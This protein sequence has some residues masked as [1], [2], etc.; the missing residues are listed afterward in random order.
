MKLKSLPPGIS[1]ANLAR[2]IAIL[3]AEG[4]DDQA[5]Y[6]ASHLPPVHDP[7]IGAAVPPDGAPEF[8]HPNET[9][10]DEEAPPASGKLPPG[11][12]QP[13]N[14][15]S[16][17]SLPP[18]IDKAYEIFGKPAPEPHSYSC[19][20]LPVPSPVRD[21]ILSLGRMIPDADLASD[22][23]DL[24]PH[25]T[26]LYGIH[27]NDPTGAFEILSH[28]RPIN[29]K[30][31]AVS[32]FAG[33]EYDVVKVEVE[34]DQL[35]RLNEQLR[36]LP[37]T[38]KFK[39][40]RQHVTIAYVAPGLGAV[41]A[42]RFGDL[43]TSCV[44]PQAVFSA[45]DN[46]RHVYPLGRQIVVTKS[47]D[48][49]EPRDEKGEWSASAH[50]VRVPRSARAARELADA[51]RDAVHEESGG[52]TKD[53]CI[54]TAEAVQSVYPDAEVWSGG[55]E[56]LSDDQAHTIV[57]I[58]AHFIDVTA[59]QFGGP[60][61]FVS[62]S[63][64]ENVYPDFE[65]TRHAPL[66]HLSPPAKKIASRIR[67]A[68]TGRVEKAAL[69]YLNSATGGALVAPASG[70]RS[71]RK[72]R[73]TLRRACKAALARI[74]GDYDSFPLTE[75]PAPAPDASDP[76]AFVFGD[77]P[78]F[79]KSL[80]S[81]P[82]PPDVS[83][84]PAPVATPVRRA[85]PELSESAAAPTS[86]PNAKSAPAPTTTAPAA[87]PSEPKAPA[88]PK[89]ASEPAEPRAPA[90]PRPASPRSRAIADAA[91]QIDVTPHPVHGNK[92]E[93]NTR[94]DY[95]QIEDR[96][97]PEE[98]NQ[99]DSHLGLYRDG[100]VN[101][102]LD[103]HDPDSDV[104]EDVATREAWW[105]DEDVR[106]HAH[107]LIDENADDE[108]R[109][110]AVSAI[111]DWYGDTRAHGTRAIDE[112][113]DHLSNDHPELSDRVRGL[114]DTAE[115]EIEV[116]RQRQREQSTAAERESLEDQYDDSDDRIYYLR[117]FHRD[118]E[119]DPRFAESEPVT[120]KWGVDEDGDPSFHFATS[121]GAPYQ[122]SVYDQKHGG[123][124]LPELVFRDG[125][126]SYKA[127]GAGNAHE[128]FSQ[129]VPAVT[130]LVTKKNMPSLSFTAAEPSRQRLY[131]RLVRTVA[132]AAPQ[133]AALAVTPPSGP[134]RYLVV[135]RDQLEQLRPVLESIPGASE[136]TVE[137]LVKAYEDFRVADDLFAN[138]KRS[139]VEILPPATHTQ[140]EWWHTP[141]GWA[142][143]DQGG[144]APQDPKPDDGSPRVEK[145]LPAAT[146]VHRPKPVA[147]P[148]ESGG[149]SFARAPKPA[150]SPAAPTD[151]PTPAAPVEP[152]PAPEPVA[153]APE[154]AP[155]AAPAT[156][157]PNGVPSTASAS[158]SAPA[159]VPP[160][161]A[162]PH[163]PAIPDWEHAPT[164]RTQNRYR[165]RHT[166]DVR[167][168]STA[169]QGRSL[170]Q[171]QS[172]ANYRAARLAQPAALSTDRYWNGT[173]YVENDSGVI[174]A[175]AAEAHGIDPEHLTALVGGMPGTRVTVNHAPAGN[176]E[177]TSLRLDHPDATQWSRTL[178]QNPDGSLALSNNAFFLRPSAQ[179][180]GFGTTAF[181]NQVRAAVKAG[182]S[183]IS[184][185]A[186]RAGAG[187]S[188]GSMNGYVTWPRLGY[189]APLEKHQLRRLP[190]ELKGA[191][192]VL[193]LYQTPAGR[194][195]WKK[196]GTTTS[197]T[198]DVTPGS[199]SLKA[200]NTY[201]KSK[202][203]PEIEYPPELHA[204]NQ[205]KQ[206]ER[207]AKYDAKS[208]QR[209]IDNTHATWARH[210][211]SSGF[212][213][214]RVRSAVEQSLP[215]NPHTSLSDRERLDV[216]YNNTINRM[217]RMRFRS[218]VDNIPTEWHPKL[219]ADARA[220]G[221]APKDVLHRARSLVNDSSLHHEPDT[222]TAQ[223]R[224]LGAALR[225]LHADRISQLNDALDEHT[226]LRKKYADR[227]ES[228][229]VPVNT[230]HENVRTVGANHLPALAEPDARRAAELAF[231]EV[232][233]R[234]VESHNKGNL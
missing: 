168:T 43:D 206:R 45:P 65:R 217:A 229:G 39:D 118:N 24:D 131:D 34:S 105:R 195:W 73:R 104:D 127:T 148:T 59:D 23:R 233:R 36:S 149:S 42:L 80:A 115:D 194:E 155:A 52:D 106:D 134:K 108:T 121:E 57:K 213:P 13:S 47:F 28:F 11:I 119:D 113:A 2:A 30:L 225:S 210:A 92:L 63:L 156:F 198:F 76:L 163:D 191:K 72:K 216:E 232:A 165:N 124:T 64:P 135:L 62:D 158:A 87:P 97:T 180:T 53:W 110:S 186:G 41:Y 85:A 71:R 54:T 120:G 84:P 126:G 14:K 189:D 90:A 29:L 151:E 21:R 83:P 185:T 17:G 94:H 178:H 152:S 69:S 211:V 5:D 74:V 182:V 161:P 99:M 234:A 197:M 141:H 218:R 96:M 166:G 146:P 122:I 32:V 68:M 88:E 101:E 203:K 91:S 174:G 231:T 46:T 3:R 125:K 75:Y 175:R 200:L 8:L 22:G 40:Y 25:T 20:Y 56:G 164:E 107:S 219:E 26:A 1:P 167:Y 81:E 150:A 169:P 136:H 188:Y 139:K 117:N 137:T 142:D 44:C 37:H 58:G 144:A 50:G 160:T 55:Y 77:A 128:V 201:L 173:A 27:T 228:Q 227:V 102:Q 18:K 16:E 78:R 154:P 130:A 123:H 6:L 209:A 79:R 221:V 140:I 33:D 183:R 215:Q 223:K 207:R 212:D 132:A 204:A 100:W 171:R 222:E 9:S 93:I 147:A 205:D 199:P 111:D 192:T 4:K 230:F 193:D 220:I 224:I 98:R 31:G 153:K 187:S 10:A 172:H 60:E 35:V 145:A 82:R 116:E 48:P 51:I 196:H 208:K 70:L 12:P 129:V 114:S 109:N 184:T 15:A 176:G 89:A 38:N 66:A 86:S 138:L 202:G 67:L 162:D 112:L 103:N 133:Y 190:P 49:S 95:D 19:V 179:G 159:P 61:V 7:H 157:S 181:A 170:E 226:D 177:Y 143:D 214:A